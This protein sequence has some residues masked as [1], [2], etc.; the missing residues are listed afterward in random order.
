M[1]LL[2]RIRFT[3]R[4]M[5]AYKSD[6]GNLVSDPYFAIDSVL[7]LNFKVL[8]ERGIRVIALD[9][10]GVLTPHGRRKPTKEVE[11]WLFDLE[12][13]FGGEN[14]YLL[15]NKPTEERKAYF[16][17]NYPKFQFISGVRKKP[18]P[19][20]MEK[21]IQKAHVLPTEVALVDDRLLT[22]CLAALIAK[23]KPIYIKKAQSDFKGELLSEVFFA[24]LR[25]LEK[26]WV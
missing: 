22:G 16:K 8:K 5:K 18:Y 23:A 20:G 1:S 25:K 3:L 12:R 14:I 11:S 21:I 6:L 2:K 26:I 7:D 17:E 15:S 4:E 13:N 19:D 10:D 24:I 9:F